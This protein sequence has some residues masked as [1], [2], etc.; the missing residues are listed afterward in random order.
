MITG[1]AN[2]QHDE[3]FVAHFGRNGEHLQSF[4]IGAPVDSIVR[5]P[6]GSLALA[7]HFWFKLQIG[8]FPLSSDPDFEAVFLARIVP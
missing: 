4:R 8:N 5:L 1:G 2:P 7:G 6:D 3:G